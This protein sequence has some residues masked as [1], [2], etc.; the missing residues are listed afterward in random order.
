MPAP[1]LH[2]R[3]EDALAALRAEGLT[4]TDAEV[5][6]LCALRH[7]CDTPERG[8]VRDVLGG[9]LAILLKVGQGRVTII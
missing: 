4:P 8:R 6:W 9:P 1:A 5:G 2:P 3:L 7:D